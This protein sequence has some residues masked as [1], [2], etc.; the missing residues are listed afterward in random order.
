[1]EKTEFFGTD[2][3]QPVTSHYWGGGQSLW[4]LSRPNT[5][6]SGLRFQ[7]KMAQS[8][9]TRHN[10]QMFKTISGAFGAGSV[11][12]DPSPPRGPEPKTSHSQKNHSINPWGGGGRTH[13]KQWPKMQQRQVVEWCDSSEAES[14]LLL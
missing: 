1:M 13:T 12:G 5:R 9:S 11:Q 4:Q 2:T 8:E 7:S 3:N 6:N 10:G 14:G